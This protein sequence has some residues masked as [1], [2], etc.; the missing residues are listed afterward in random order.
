MFYSFALQQHPNIRY[1][2]AV[3]RLSCFELYSMLSAVGISVSPDRI[4]EQVIGNSSFLSF[5]SAPLSDAALRFLSLHSSLLIMFEREGELLRPIPVSPPFF[6]PPDLPEILKFK[7][8]TSVTFTRMML[9]LALSFSPDPFPSSRLTVLDP[10]CGKATTLFC[11]AQYGMNAAGIDSNA[12]SIDEAQN[13]FSR[14]LKYHQKKHTI[15]RYSETIRS[16]A[17]PVTEFLFSDTKD[18][19]HQNKRSK[20][21]LAK[22]D[23]SDCRAL[24]RHTQADMIVTDL[25]YGIQHAPQSGCRVEPFTVL[26]KRVIPD[27]YDALAPGGSVAVSFNSLTLPR[28][29]VIRIFRDSG[30]RFPYL[31]DQFD[32][33][34]EVEQAVLRDM[35]LAVKPTN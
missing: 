34:H 10:M 21:T 18:H 26:L 33:T 29:N 4:R 15:R 11:A 8:K 31:V 1:R 2:E 19:F 7:G 6:L 3:S 25:P 13:Y 5:E 24:T 32:F 27:W 20:L 17:V 35:L 14:Y 12:R 30:F 28:E 22:G 16:H 23:T 9:N